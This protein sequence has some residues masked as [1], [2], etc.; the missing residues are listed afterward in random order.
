MTW[1]ECA[2]VSTMAML[3]AITCTGVSIYDVSAKQKWEGTHSQWQNWF[4]LFT[5]TLS[6]PRHT[7]TGLSLG[8]KLWQ[9]GRCGQAWL[10]WQLFA[11]KLRKQCAWVFMELENHI[12]MQADH[13]C[14]RT[15]ASTQ[16][17]FYTQTARRVMETSFGNILSQ[18]GGPTA[19]GQVSQPKGSATRLWVR[20]GRSWDGRC[21]KALLRYTCTSA[22]RTATIAPEKFRPKLWHKAAHLLWDSSVE[23]AASCG[24]ILK[25][26]H[27]SNSTYNLAWSVPVE[28]HDIHRPHSTYGRP[29][30]PGKLQTTSV[31]QWCLWHE[32]LWSSRC[33]PVVADLFANSSSKLQADTRWESS[34][35]YCAEV[36]VSLST[37]ARWLPRQ[38][39][40]EGMAATGNLALH[41]QTALRG[42]AAR[43][44][45]LA[46]TAAGCF[47]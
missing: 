30:G 37:F 17:I 10:N 11:M 14:K 32:F 15:K 36:A 35:P 39:L 21:V 4:S 41:V 44:S 33:A 40:W 24:N 12:V 18:V 22:S 3:H 8:S 13:A 16:P 26:M 9:H 23:S 42:A 45:C 25:E 1:L 47:A 28:R 31:V 34:G 46:F 2:C 27:L 19:L 38:H 5:R 43:Q 7:P 29:D 20:S 6:W